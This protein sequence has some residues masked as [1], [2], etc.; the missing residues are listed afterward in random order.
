ML[1]WKVGD[2]TITSVMESET[3]IPGEFI[4]AG[5]SPEALASHAWLR[6]H[7]VDDAGNI[8]LRIQAFVVESEGMRIVVDTCIGNDKPR[9][10]PIWDRLQT[11]FLTD[12]A[13]AGFPRESVDAAVCTHMHVDHVGWNTMLVDP[14][15]AAGVPG[16]TRA[17]EAGGDAQDE[18]VWIPTFPNARYCFVAQELAHWQASDDAEDRRI[19]ADSIRPILDA[20]LADLVGAD[21]RLTSE[22]FLVPTPGHTPGHVSVN[23]ASA[24]ASAVITGDV[25]HHPAQ[26]AHPEWNATFDSAPKQAEETRRAFLERYGDA[27]VL[28]VGSH[29][30]APVAGHLVSEGS[31]WRFNPYVSD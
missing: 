19:Q 29:F 9:G 5:A 21:H 18:R 10:I 17:A 31:A 22:V 30:A 2:V 14:V 26:C 6:P 16:A 7:F 8:I 27:P 23:I 1:R 20:G 11:E 28:V 13:T 3:P 24:G 12:L 4:V 15:A 25:M